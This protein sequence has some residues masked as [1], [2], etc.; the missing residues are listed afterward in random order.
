[1]LPLEL[2][3]TTKQQQLFV[4]VSVKHEIERKT[5]H[6]KGSINAVEPEARSGKSQNFE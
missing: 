5:N 6:C 2:T 1:M 3:L 4:V